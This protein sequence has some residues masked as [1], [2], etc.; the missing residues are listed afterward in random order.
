VELVTSIFC[1]EWLLRELLIKRIAQSDKSRG[2][3][4]GMMNF[5]V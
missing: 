2:G 3:I 1:L 4:S 5:G